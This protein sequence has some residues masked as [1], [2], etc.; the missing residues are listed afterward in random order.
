ML[1][2]RDSAASAT[3]AFNFTLGEQHWSARCGS[4]YNQASAWRLSFG[5]PRSH[6]GLGG[7]GAAAGGLAVPSSQAI[8]PGRRPTV[9]TWK[10][11]AEEALYFRDSASFGS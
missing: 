2:G 11:T 9:A 5:L 10:S 8:K 1:S 7:R 3:L 6:A 4:C